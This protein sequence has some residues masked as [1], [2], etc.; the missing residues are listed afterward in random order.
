LTQRPA[1]AHN[2]R[3]VQPE[4]SFGP[5]GR[6]SKRFCQWEKVNSANFWWKNLP[7]EICPTKQLYL[8]LERR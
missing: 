4:S 7:S 1:I 5:S 6:H 3:S 2:L 8:L